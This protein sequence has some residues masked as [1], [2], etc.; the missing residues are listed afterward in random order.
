MKRVIILLLVAGMLVPFLP[1]CMPSGTYDRVK[2]RNDM[3]DEPDWRVGADKRLRDAI[4]YEN[5]NPYEYNNSIAM[6]QNV[7]RHYSNTAA[8]EE[9]RIAIRRIKNN[10]TYRSDR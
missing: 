7:I 10:P 4:A 3:N 1:S 5:Q 8:A 2:R 9:A 6:Y